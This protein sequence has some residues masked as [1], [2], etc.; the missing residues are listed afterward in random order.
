MN[1]VATIIDQ[2]VPDTTNVMCFYTDISVVD[3]HYHS[4][5]QIVVSTRTTF[6][7]LIGDQHY[8]GLKGFII[9]KYTRHS[10]SAVSGSF[11][12][13]YIESRS[14][15]GKKLRQMLGGRAFIDIQNILSNETLA[16]L[17]ADFSR[18]ITPAET[19]E[20]SDQ[21]L[22][23]IFGEVA[24]SVSEEQMDARISK[25][26]HYI[27]ENIGEH[28]TLEDVAGHIYLSPERT[29][30][31][32]LEQTEIQFSQYLLWKRI[33][34]VLK[35]VLKDGHNFYHAAL[36]YG[37]TDQSHFNRFFKRMFGISATMIIKNSRFIHF[38]YPEL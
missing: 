9:D 35:A 7:S 25:A 22:C 36:T 20:L 37:F 17:L 23:N 32:F 38:I 10:C 5:Y 12:V 16:Q 8:K 19:K 30:H 31:L 26:I 13:Y 15:L 24:E 27:T 33:K 11:L 4:C 1:P 28:L 14:M 6:D 18:P 3:V 34:A 21:L 29:R 2:K